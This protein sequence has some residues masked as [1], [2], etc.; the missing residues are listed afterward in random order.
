MC[1]IEEAD[2]VKHV[3]IRN[4]ELGLSRERTVLWVDDQLFTANKY[5][6]FYYYLSR[7]KSEMPAQDRQE[8]H[9][10]LKTT[11]MAAR[12]YI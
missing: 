4:V 10:I 3:Y 9:C 8:V 7:M 2:G 11:S 1:K 6:T 12:A 5:A